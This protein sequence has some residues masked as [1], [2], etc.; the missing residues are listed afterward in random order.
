M[1]QCLSTGVSFGYRSEQVLSFVFGHGT[2]NWGYAPAE[3]T[4]LY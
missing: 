3:L 4:Q 2:Q 1:H